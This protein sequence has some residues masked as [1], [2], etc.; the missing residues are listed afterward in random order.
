LERNK[1]ARR[2]CANSDEE[3]MFGMVG[4]TISDFWFCISADVL[5][6]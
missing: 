5:A 3:V 2:S 4:Q 1:L 6:L